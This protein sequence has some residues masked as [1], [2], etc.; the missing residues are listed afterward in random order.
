MKIDNEDKSRLLRPEQVINLDRYPITDID[1]LLFK[2]LIQRLRKELDQQ[3]YVVLPD[4][5]RPAARQQSIEQIESVLHLAND[6]QSDRNCY[7]Q[8][9]PD[10]SFPQDHPRNVFLP[11][12]TRMI[13]ADLLQPDSP[14]KAL[15][16]WDKMKKLVAGIVGVDNLYDNEDPLQPVNALC[17]RNGDRSSWHFDS[18]NAFTMTL[19]LQAP[20]QGGHFEIHPNTRSDDDQSYDRVGKVVS[21]DEDGIVEVGREEGSLCIFRGCNSLHRVSSVKGNR[22]RIMGVFVY[23][24]ETGIT[25]DPEVNETVYG[26]KTAAPAN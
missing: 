9:E 16:Y 10:S 19:M 18:N 4:F 25:G 23:E 11:A 1:S 20:E 21:G 3:Q 8:R 7:L 14:L 22:L 2:E 12:S 26:R 17:Y 15:Y 13:A 6:N 24:N 5:I